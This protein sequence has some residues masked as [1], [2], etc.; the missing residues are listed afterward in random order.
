MTRATEAFDAYDYTTALEVTE[1]FFWEFCDDYLELVKERAYGDR[2]RRREPRRP[3]R[4]WPSPCDV[5][6]RLLAPFL[7]YVTEEV[8]SWWRPGSVHRRG[9]AGR[10]RPRRRRRRR[11]PRPWTRSRPRAGRHPRRQ[12]AGQGLACAPSS[13]ASRCA[14][15]PSSSRPPPLARRDLRAA[16]RVVG[17]L[18]FVADDSTEVHVTA[19]VVAPAAQPG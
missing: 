7:P 19:E 17:D 12:V 8:W 14:D 13:R 6:L 4:P 5:Q 18:V 2:R 16:G 1:Q 15:R 11:R 10:G 9:V 3:G